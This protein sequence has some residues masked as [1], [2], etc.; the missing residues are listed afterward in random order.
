LRTVSAVA[1]V[2][3]ASNSGRAAPSRLDGGPCGGQ[4]LLDLGESREIVGL[5]HRH[6]RRRVMDVA[7]HRRSASC[8]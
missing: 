2:I 8:C 1:A 5:R 6:D 3:Q 7:V 4:L